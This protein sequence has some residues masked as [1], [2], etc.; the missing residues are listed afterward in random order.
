MDFFLDIESFV[1]GDPTVEFDGFPR[2][3]HGEEGV[4]MDAGAFWNF[5]DPLGAFPGGDDPSFAIAAAAGLIAVEGEGVSFLLGFKSPG[6]PEEDAVLNADVFQGACAP[7]VDLESEV[8]GL[9]SG[10]D[11]DCEFDAIGE[12]TAGFKLSVFF[13]DPF[14]GGEDDVLAF[15]NGRGVRVSDVKEGPSDVDGFRDIENEVASIVPRGEDADFG[16]PLGVDGVLQIIGAGVSS[17]GVW[18]GG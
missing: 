7:V 1:K 3:A 12:D 17:S 13:T 6:S 8:D 15:P 18:E 5:P 9:R 11:L 10:L 16:F 14:L 4:G 2:V